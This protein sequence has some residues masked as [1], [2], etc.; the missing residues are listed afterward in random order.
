MK[1]RQVRKRS[2]RVLCYIG[3]ALLNGGCIAS[4]RV[5][6]GRLGMSTGPLRASLYNHLIG[7]GFLALLMLLGQL[8]MS[9]MSGGTTLN[10]LSQAPAVSYLGGVLGALFVAIN[11]FVL[12]RIGVLRTTVLVIGGQMLAGVI[13]D[14][15]GESSGMLWKL[16]GVGLIVMG[17]YLSR[18][19]STGS[20]IREIDRH[21]EIKSKSAATNGR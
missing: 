14:A 11:S 1:R 19:S 13:L 16:A 7:F 12:P 2:I 20:Q 21:D 5:I 10:S 8:V 3:L 15:G 18:K 17:V 4:S 9:W 6:N